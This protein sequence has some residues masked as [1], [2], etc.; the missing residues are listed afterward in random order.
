MK[1]FK[2]FLLIFVV[3]VIVVLVGGVIALR[4]AYPPAK[5]KGILITKMSEF[6]HREVEIKDVSIGFG[7]LD[8]EGFR[9][10]EKPA[11][12]QGVFVE[13]GKFIIRPDLF[14]LLQGKISIS[15]IILDEPKINI[16][17]NKDNSFNF[18]DLMTKTTDV[19]STR[20]LPANGS[21]EGEVHKVKETKVEKKSATAE[22]PIAFIVSKLSLSNGTVK[23]TDR[24][25]QDMSVELKNINLSLSGISLVSPF[26]VDMSVDVLQKKVNASLSFNFSGV[27]NMKQ[28]NLKIKQAVVKI[29]D[30][31]IKVS[32]NVDKFMDPDKLTFAVNV[33]GEKFALEKITKIAPLPKELSITGEPNINVDVSG[34]MNKIQVKGG[35]DM[36]K[37]SIAF[38][39]MFSKPKDAEMSL[40]TDIVFENMDVLKINNVSVALGAVKNSL[41]GKVTGFKKNQIAMDLNVLLEK[42]DLKTLVQIIPMMKDFGVSGLVDGNVLVSGDLKILSIS[43]KVNIQDIQSIKKDLTAKVS[44]GNLDF[45]A[46]ISNLKKDISFTLSGDTIDIK[47]PEQPKQAAAQSGKGAKS[48]P[49]SS[50]TKDQGQGTSQPAELR[51]AATNQPSSGGQSQSVA[52]AKVGVPKDISITGDLKLKKFIFQNFQITDCSAKVSLLNAELNI[53]PFYMAMCKG[54]ISGSIYADLSDLEPTRLKF[55][56]ATDVSNYDLHELVLESGVQ[57]KAQFWGV[58]E[59]KVKISGTGSNMTGLN[60]NGSL[61]IKNVKVNNSKI[62]DQLAAVSQMPQVKET[63][64]KSAT[65]GFNIKSGI[66]EITNTK[67]D[68]GDKLDA[69]LSGNVNLVALRQDIGGKVKFTKEYSRGDMAKYTADVEGRVTVPFTVKGTFDDPKVTLDWNSIAKTAIQNQGKEILMKEGAKLLKGLFGK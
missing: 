27:V 46:R 44:K 52:S 19:N 16:I 31:G 15:K 28:Q 51:S 34:N 54:S 43:G 23:F 62:L 47:M 33:K 66:I 69:Y 20:S 21:V 3:C 64:F 35:I 50:V 41:S 58:A 17:R 10:S 42:F 36:K 14:A 29:N 6:L 60:G 38:G 57:I 12:K 13:A 24:S 4:I 11:F 8:V 30:A 32:G 9:I 56:F 18:S 55:N 7:G 5:V 63:S 25:A 49:S 1:K 59:G 48:Q 45:S 53:R 2:K 22:L 67:T 39:D 37:V 40:M 68:G 61:V 26:L 65:G